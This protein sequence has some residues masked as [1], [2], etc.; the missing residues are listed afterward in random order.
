MY[1]PSCSARRRA[2]I[3]QSSRVLCGNAHGVGLADF[4]HRK[5][6]ASVDWPITRR[7]ALTARAPHKA[8][9][10]L[11]LRS[12]REALEAAVASL[13]VPADRLRLV[14]ISDTRHTDECW[15]SEPAVAEALAG[16]GSQQLES[17]S[18]RFDRGGD[19]VF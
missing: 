13:G 2:V 16:P 5:L 19:F 4:V 14:R 18:V 1:S 3:R 9:L 12:D 10:P 11:V 7:N 6:A 15:V 17:R 8:R